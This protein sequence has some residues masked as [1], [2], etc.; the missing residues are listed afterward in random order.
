MTRAVIDEAQRAVLTAQVAAP[1]ETSLADVAVRV[2]TAVAAA[3][4]ASARTEW[5]ERFS[6]L[7]AGGSFLPSV[8]TLANAGRGGQLAACFVLEVADSLDS[9]YGTLHRAAAIQQGSGGV[10][11]E[12]SA[13]RPRGT[14]IERSG[15]H[16][17]G[18]VAFAELFA[19]SAHVMGMAGRRAGAHL[20]ILR[21]DHPDVV[22][23]VR[24][25]RDAP[26]RFPQL[27]LA[28][29]VSDGLLRAAREN[30]SWELHHPV[31]ATG[32]IAARDLL[33]EIAGSILETGD[34]TLLFLDRIEA[35][36]PTP[37]LGAL[38]ATNP[39]GEQPL[40]SGESC[41]LGSL[42]LPSFLK[43]DGALDEGRLGRAVRDAVRFLDDALEVNAWPDN[44][45]AR[46]SQRTRKVGLGIMGLA[47]LL[48]LRGMPYDGPEARAFVGRVLGLVAR[49][50]DAATGALGEERGVFPAWE[51]GP[52]RRNA[53]TRAFAPTGTLRL[54]AGCSPGIEPFMAPRVALQTEPRELIWT[55]TWL[56]QWLA[57]RTAD[58]TSVLD[59][60]GAGIG[61]QQ[62]PDL[63]DGDRVLLRRA[64]EIS[65]ENQLSMQACAQHCVDGAISKTVHL[66]GETPLDATQVV[67]WIQQARKL[68]CKGVAFYR[69]RSEDAA[70]R[71]DLRAACLHSCGN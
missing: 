7:I 67:D 12:F 42:Q 17:P 23:F 29:G 40:L 52:P 64:W 16:A 20:A 48:L 71:I 50:A 13:L 30:E 2:A 56:V 47:D 1:G 5:A 61:H 54:L 44:E 62:L 43:H 41:V 59:A 37:A 60:L 65:P 27:G 18:P 33:R 34:P 55:D 8:P 31:R 51:R 22:E 10:G 21:D 19:G 24:A 49:E 36:N 46:A 9:I 53:T 28:V 32:R 58:P 66:A 26:G 6:A 69:R 45:I 39:C 38:G 14:P 57:G 11:V 15:G 4:A 35:D 70:T 25:K 63:S 3:E 68:E